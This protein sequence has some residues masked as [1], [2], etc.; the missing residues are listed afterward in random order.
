[1]LDVAFC[2]PKGL[3]PSVRRQ[4]RAHGAPDANLRHEYYEFR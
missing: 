4:M 2:G 1:L 3:M